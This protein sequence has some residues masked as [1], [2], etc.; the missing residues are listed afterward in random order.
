MKIDIRRDIVKSERSDVTE[1]DGAA[2]AS[3][4]SWGSAVKIA[5]QGTNG[6]DVNRA[7]IYLDWHRASAIYN[8]ARGRR[9]ASRKL[10]FRGAIL[11]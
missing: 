8:E 10:I 6:L 1:A 5:R 9:L 4:I 3:L 2:V 7:C 11:I